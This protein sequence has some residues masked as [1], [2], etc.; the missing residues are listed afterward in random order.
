M[1]LVA[2]AGKF[3]FNPKSAGYILAY[4]AEVYTE[5]VRRNI[6]TFQCESRVNSSGCV[7]HMFSCTPHPWPH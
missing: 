3:V 6:L 1:V 5:D 2:Q 7:V 4:S